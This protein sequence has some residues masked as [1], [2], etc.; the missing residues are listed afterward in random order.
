MKEVLFFLTISIGFFACEKKAVEGNVV[1]G[2]WK[3]TEY[4][5][6]PGDGSGKWMP[7]NSDNPSY[8][9]FKGG[10]SLV[11]TPLNVYGS[12][13]YQIVNDSLM[14]FLR[15]VEKFQFRYQLSGKMLILYPPCIEQCGSKYIKVD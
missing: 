13:H 6:D 8:I 4:L 7:A 2:R 11:F 5:A 12:D 15:G 1:E 9:E 14:I 3:L 10:G